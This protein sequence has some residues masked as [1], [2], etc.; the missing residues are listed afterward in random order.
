MKQYC[1]LSFTWW[2]HA[3]NLYTL[4]ITVLTIKYNFF[5]TNSKYKQHC[6]NTLY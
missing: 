3:K 2:F 4:T 6:G 5:V 1:V